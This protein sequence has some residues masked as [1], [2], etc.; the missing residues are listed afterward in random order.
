MVE[1]PATGVRR[2]LHLEAVTGRDSRV[3]GNGKFPASV[4]RAGPTAIS[5]NANLAPSSAALCLDRGTSGCSEAIWLR[6]E[7]AI[8]SRT[9]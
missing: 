2:Q 7:P 3:T 1:L 6:A 4:D 9:S 5:F 8:K